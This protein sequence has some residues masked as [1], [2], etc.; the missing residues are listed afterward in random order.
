MENVSQTYVNTLWLWLI[1]NSNNRYVYIHSTFYIFCST[2]FT[3]ICRLA[4]SNGWPKSASDKNFEILL[5]NYFLSKNFY[6]HRLFWKYLPPIT[7]HAS[8]RRIIFWNTCLQVFSCILHMCASISVFN[9]ST[10]VGSLRHTLFFKYAH[11][12]KS[13]GVKLRLLAGHMP[14]D[15]IRSSKN[16]V[17]TSVVYLAVWAVAP[18]C[19]NQAYRSSSSRR[20]IKFCIMPV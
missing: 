19:W 18:S 17:R 9:S 11:K 10:V 7:W 4:Y 14:F 16:S 8:N 1:V 5:K 6:N 20:A 15:M 13:G 2:H 12:K 3:R